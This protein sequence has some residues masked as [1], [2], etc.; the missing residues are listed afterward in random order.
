M[1]E[2][3]QQGMEEWKMLKYSH[4]NGNYWMR[5]FVCMTLGDLKK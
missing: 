2:V 4:G 3:T 1:L 5:V